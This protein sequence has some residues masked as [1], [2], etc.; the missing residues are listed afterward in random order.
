MPKAYWV[1][2]VEVSNPDPYAIY[3][4]EATACFEKYG[5]NVLARGGLTRVLEG[6][7]RSRNVVIEFESMDRALEC[8]HSPE[9]Q[10]AKRHRED[11]AEANL[12]IIEGI[13]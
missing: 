13:N 10:S 8:F 5:G 4:R 3:A 11:N 6:P 12:M 1:A 2:H 9:Y 7:E